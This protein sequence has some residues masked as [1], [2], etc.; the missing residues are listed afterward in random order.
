VNIIEHDV[1]PSLTEGKTVIMKGF[2][3]TVLT[4]AMC[5]TRS[6]L[7]KNRLLELHKSMIQHCV[8]EY[9]VPPPLYL[10]LRP[11]TDVAL[12]RLRRA[13]EMPPGIQDPR[14]YIEK[15]NKGFEFYGSLEGQTVVSIDADA[16]IDKVTDKALGIIIDS[17]ES[18]LAVA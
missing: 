18:E 12:E 7:E 15:L 8:I 4:H 16:S 10:W 11:S 6:E 14:S 9:G 5:H 1:L 2:G 17:T 3:G 13:G